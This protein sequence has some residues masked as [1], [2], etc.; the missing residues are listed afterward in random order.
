MA[1]LVAHIEG[2]PGKQVVVDFLGGSPILEDQGHCVC[3]FR[4][5]CRAVSW[6]KSIAGRGWL[7]C[8]RCFIPLWWRIA[9]HGI[10]A[11]RRV[12]GLRAWIVVARIVETGAGIAKSTWCDPAHAIRNAHSIY[13]S[14]VARIGRSPAGA[15]RRDTEHWRSGHRPRRIEL[16]SRAQAVSCGGGKRPIRSAAESCCA[17]AR[18][19]AA[20]ASALGERRRHN[21]SYDQRN[22]CE[23]LH[24][25]SLRPP[26]ERFRNNSFGEW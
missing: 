1:L 20:R 2:R 8:G 23:P 18:R 11:L 4:L 3:G 5:W 26:D 15:A 7:G 16:W 12:T 10:V 6:L 14:T 24:D 13:R 17:M 21:P 22:C 25:H 19:S 9:T